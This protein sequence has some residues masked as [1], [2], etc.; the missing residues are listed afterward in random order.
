MTFG[1]K[2]LAIP[3]AIIA[4]GIMILLSF[5][6]IVSASQV[7]PE[8]IVSGTTQ[9]NINVAQNISLAEISNLLPNLGLYNRNNSIQSME[10]HFSNNSNDTVLWANG[11]LDSSG[12]IYG[13]NFH[14]LH[15]NTTLDYR[16]YN[17]LVMSRVSISDEN[18]PLLNE[19]WRNTTTLSTEESY[20]TTVSNNG[21][22]IISHNMELTSRDLK[23]V[24]MLIPNSRENDLFLPHP[25]ISEKDHRTS[26]ATYYNSTTNIGTTRD[27]TKF[28]I[29]AQNLSAVGTSSSGLASNHSWQNENLTGTFENSTGTYH[30]QVIIDNGS[31]LVKM[32]SVP[33]NFIFD[34]SSESRQINGGTETIYEAQGT[35]SRSE[36]GYFNI[37][38][39]FLGL[40]SA[41][42]AKY[43]P[44]LLRGILSAVVANTVSDAATIVGLV[45]AFVGVV[46]TFLS[47]FVNTNGN[48]V[49][50]IELGYWH[51]NAWWESWIYEP[52]LEFGAITNQ[53]KF[54]WYY[55]E[56]PTMYVVWFTTAISV[57]YSYGY[58]PFSHYSYWPNWNRTLLS[59]F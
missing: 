4:V 16:I 19:I 51:P 21:S 28:T 35:I 37:Y 13:F 12:I 30:F 56:G 40:A 57:I 46:S 54:P 15:Q 22:T 38:D 53:L 48:L 18:T 55:Y 7:K 23:E 36:L 9:P 42:L 5:T 59:Y 31:G 43:V 44:T 14:S 41:L 20:F 8:S 33:M 50:Y 47:W 26:S 58:I 10:A 49:I 24:F 1:K 6:P 25:I 27:L 45:L 34:P 17:S 52:Y 11:S 39:S 3:G 32:N 29:V 2:Y